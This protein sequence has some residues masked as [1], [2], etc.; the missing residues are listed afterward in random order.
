MEH[1]SALKRKEILLFATT[2]MN[3]EHFM[4]SETSLTKNQKLLP[5][6]KQT[7]GICCRRQGTQS[8]CSVTTRGVRWG[9]RWEQGPGG[10]G[11]MYTFG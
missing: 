5:S 6:V 4:L 10:R 8:W 3:F 7:V 2:W 9:G 11:H 1:Y